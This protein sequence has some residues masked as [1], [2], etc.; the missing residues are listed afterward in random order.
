MEYWSNRHC[1]GG[2]FISVL[3]VWSVSHFVVYRLFSSDKKYPNW[4][5]VL[6]LGGLGTLGGLVAIGLFGI[7]NYM[8]IFGLFGAVIF[9]RSEAVKQGNKIISKVG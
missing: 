2:L 9:F 5:K 4:L 7:F 8:F 6:I 3:C 1:G